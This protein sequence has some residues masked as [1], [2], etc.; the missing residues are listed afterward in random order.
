MKKFS[1][2]NVERLSV[3]YCCLL[4]ENDKY[5]ARLKFQTHYL[6]GAFKF[7][8]PLRKFDVFLPCLHTITDHATQKVIALVPITSDKGQKIGFVSERN[9]KNSHV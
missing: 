1:L 5:L 4:N 3:C 8:P 7:S 2:S 9:R 6:D